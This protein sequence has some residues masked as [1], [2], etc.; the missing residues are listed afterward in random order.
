MSTKEF[1]RFADMLNDKLDL[2]ADMSVERIEAVKEGDTQR[3]EFIE[4]M[5]IEPL[6]LQIRYL[7]EKIKEGA[8]NDNSF[9]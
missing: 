3:V 8:K 1:L 7:V 5:M 4:Q 2:E 6:K 9:K